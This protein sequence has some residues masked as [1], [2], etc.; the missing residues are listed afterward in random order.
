[1]FRSSRRQYKQHVADLKS[2]VD[3]YERRAAH[4][5]AETAQT[6]AD[7]HFVQA[8]R[9]RQ[10]AELAQ[11]KTALNEVAVYQGMVG[12]SPVALLVSELVRDHEE[13]EARIDAAIALLRDAKDAANVTD[14]PSPL[15]DEMA[16]LLS[17]G[18]R[19]PDDPSQLLL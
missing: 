3:D 5:A 9:D 10:A 11:I 13:L 14:E 1:M 7:L 8:Q 16:R 15:V 12:V 4:C 6:Q 19:F 2:R 17:G 18:E